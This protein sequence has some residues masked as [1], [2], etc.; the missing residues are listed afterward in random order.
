[1]NLYDL[2][3]THPVWVAIRVL[4]WIVTPAVFWGSMILWLA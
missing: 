1:M 2:P 4:L 3:P